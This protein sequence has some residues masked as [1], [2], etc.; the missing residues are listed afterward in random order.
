MLLINPLQTI[1]PLIHRSISLLPFVDKCFPQTYNNCDLDRVLEAVIVLCCSFEASFGSS[2]CSILTPFRG[3]TTSHIYALLIYAEESYKE[4]QHGTQHLKILVKGRDCRGVKAIL[5][6][7]VVF[8]ALSATVAVYS[9]TDSFHKGTAALSNLILD[10]INAVTELSSGCIYSITTTIT[11]TITNEKR[12]VY[13][14][15]TSRYGSPESI[16]AARNSNH[17]KKS[18]KNGG[19]SDLQIDEV[20]YGKEVL[21]YVVENNS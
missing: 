18:K 6:Y 10:C 14:G 1:R 4:I 19:F 3:V 17:H 7:V 2:W 8:V 5:I 9:T 11:D 12:V 13:S 21:Q 15:R 20:A 16:F